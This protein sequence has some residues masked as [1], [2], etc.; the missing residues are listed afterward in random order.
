MDF[1]EDHTGG[2][3]EDVNESA[4]ELVEQLGSLAEAEAYVAEA[5]SPASRTFEGARKLVS[6]VKQVRGY[7]LIVGIGKYED[8]FKPLPGNR[9][10]PA[11]GRAAP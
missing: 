2:S 11:R 9:A 7:F 5:Y 1:A 6:Q 10:Q 8:G 3:C 4:A